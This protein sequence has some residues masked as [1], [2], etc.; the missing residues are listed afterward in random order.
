MNYL[1]PSGQA[2]HVEGLELRYGHVVALVELAVLLKEG[3]VGSA[4]NVR[5][6]TRSVV[7]RCSP[8]APMRQIEGLHEGRISGSS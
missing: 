5:D 6:F 7:E 8:S 4:D 3:G 2:L 1:S